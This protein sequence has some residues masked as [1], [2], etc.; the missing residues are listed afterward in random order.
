[1]SHPFPWTP[2]APET[3][4]E[5]YNALRAACERLECLIEASDDLTEK[6]LKRLDKAVTVMKVGFKLL[7]K[8]EKPLRV[9]LREVA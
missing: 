2:K 5:A 7:K 8:V 3:I 1:M 9:K 4:P 6:D